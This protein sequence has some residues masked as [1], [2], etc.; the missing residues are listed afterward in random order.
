MNV[1]IKTLEQVHEALDAI[2]EE[3]E[4]ANLSEKEKTQLEKIAIQ[5]RNIERSIIRQKEEELVAVLT[6][7][8]TQLK[9]LIEEIHRSSFKLT[10]V[11]HVIEKASNAVAALIKIITTATS[12]GLI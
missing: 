3:R 4:E 6:D 11:T 5:L 7:D 10:R 12:A 9:V 2:E 8:S 1:K